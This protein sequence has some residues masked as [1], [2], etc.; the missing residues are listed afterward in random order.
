MFL[1][2]APKPIPLKTDP[3]A[4]CREESGDRVSAV[5]GGNSEED[6]AFLGEEGF[7]SGRLLGLRILSPFV[8]GGAREKR[9]GDGYMRRGKFQRNLVTRFGR[10]SEPISIKRS[11]NVQ[12]N[13]SA[14]AE[15]EKKP[16][17]TDIPYM[18]PRACSQ[19]NK[20]TKT[21]R[22]H[23]KKART[24]KTSSVEIPAQRGPEA[25]LWGQP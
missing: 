20:T 18:H 14:R 1:P 2:S 4:R 10:R 24:W 21:R 16:M 3:S 12:A 9:K 6:M 11:C 17:F 23:E 19:Q 5:R 22:K 8:P 7:D 15:C 13:A 25:S